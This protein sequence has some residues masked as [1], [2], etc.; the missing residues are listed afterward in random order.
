MWPWLLG[1]YPI[2]SSDE[3]N[4]SIRAQLHESYHKEM[5]EWKKVEKIH[6]RILAAE[7]RERQE[8]WKREYAANM[9]HIGTLKLRR[10]GEGEG[11]GENGVKTEDENVECELSDELKHNG[12]RRDEERQALNGSGK[13]EE[14]SEMLAENGQLTSEDFRNAVTP[15]PRDHSDCLPN[16]TPSSTTPHVTPPSRG[17]QSPSQELNSISIISQNTTSF[18]S[19]H[20][21]HPSHVDNYI[22]SPQNDIVTKTRSSSVDSGHSS[23]GN[24]GNSIGSDPSN[25]LVNGCHGDIGGR[26]DVNSSGDSGL[27][28]WNRDIGMTP[29]QG[30]ADGTEQVSANATEGERERN[31]EREGEGEG[32]EGGMELDEKGKQFS[33]ELIKIDKDIP[34]CDRDYW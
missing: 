22:T 9:S 7:E 13:D 10:E 25:S 14:G 16:G 27:L 34:R 24:L 26:S 23:T 18:P 29:R 3:E 12:S 8:R 1:L 17:S 19:P 28:E 4:E 6:L 15:V 5:T 11:G 32:E 30:G 21:A 2:T 33:E 31:G 20:C